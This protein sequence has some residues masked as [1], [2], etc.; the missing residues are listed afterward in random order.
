MDT[1]DII[2]TCVYYARFANKVARDYRREASY[3]DSRSLLLR[4]WK[5]RAA[6]NQLNHRDAMMQAARM[7]KGYTHMYPASADS[8][9]E[10]TSP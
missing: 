4:P 5:L 7:L 1:D 3:T 6:Q 8:T 9:I 10:D 2:A